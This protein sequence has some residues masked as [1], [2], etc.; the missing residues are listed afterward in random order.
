MTVLHKNKFFFL[1]M[2][3]FFF[4]NAAVLFGQTGADATTNSTTYATNP[5][6]DELYDQEEVARKQG[7]INQIN[8]LRGFLPDATIEG[9]LQVFG[10]T[11]STQTTAGVSETAKFSR[12][13]RE[14][15]S[16][17]DVLALQKVLNS[18][19][20][21]LVS[22][23]GPGS[24]GNETS[25]FGP[26]T[27]LAVIAFQNVHAKEILAPA[28]LLVGTGFVGPN[29]RSFLENAASLAL[30]VSSDT[31]FSGETGVPEIGASVPSQVG[32]HVRI[33]SITPGSGPTG[34]LV[35]IKGTG[36]LPT[37][38]IVFAGANTYLNATSTDG[39]TI[40]AIMEAPFVI[41]DNPPESLKQ[42]ESDGFEAYIAEDGR[43]IVPSNFANLL[44][45]SFTSLPYQVFVK[46]E[47]GLSNN[48]PFV[49]KFK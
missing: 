8:S 40:H 15:D 6:F 44:D 5:S 32:A 43:Q 20:A 14:G 42:T 46:N 30:S 24:P 31:S 37:R 41:M 11:S 19:P 4:G 48:I 36:F 28:G 12:N 25:F 49:L 13:L 1:F 22:E 2:A 21:T 33:N 9:L 35:T 27:K 18:D 17:P 3:L 45:A 26:R 38:N 10:V 39:V 34:T 47:N 7:I 29:T 23:T 16:G